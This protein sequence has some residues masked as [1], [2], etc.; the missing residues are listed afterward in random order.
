MEVS[1]GGWVQ[2]TWANSVI[3]TATHEVFNETECIGVKMKATDEQ[4]S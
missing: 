1:V 3:N 4:N 2:D